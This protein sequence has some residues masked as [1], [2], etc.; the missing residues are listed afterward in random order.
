[1]KVLH[2][3]SVATIGGIEMLCTDIAK[4]NPK[5][6]VFAILF[7]G[8]PVEKQLED[9]GAHCYSLYHI[10]K[11]NVVDYMGKL[12]DICKSEQIDIVV[13]HH[14]GLSVL[15]YYML[16][17]RHLPNLKYVRYLHS[18]FEEK[19]YYTYGPLMNFFARR[20]MTAMYR[21]SDRLIAVSECVKNSFLQNFPI[22]QNKIRVIYNGISADTLH[23][24]KESY[25]LGKKTKKSE[26]CVNVIYMGRLEKV[27]GID[28]LI[29]AFSQLINEQT[30]MKL[31]LL[32]DGNARDEFEEL[33]HQKGIE[34]SVSFEGFQLEKEKYL[35][36]SDVFVYPSRCQEAFGISIIEAMSCGL[37]CIASKVGGIPEILCDG[38]NGYLFP[39]EDVTILKQ[40]LIIAMN[41]V[42]EEEQETIVANAMKTAN[43]FTI[44]KTIKK[45]NEVYHTIKLEKMEK[46]R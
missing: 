39:N 17:R 41:L 38:E 37:I 19:Y 11:W 27:K 16:L 8:G 10:P 21:K 36:K 40:K 18:V 45:L 42:K 31:Y 30:H 1:M 3:L 6:N 44:E 22:D 20:M 43:E 46:I 7:K 35:Q 13:I 28:I 5:N 4:E 25:L 12:C 15:V 33:V 2:L 14:E 24:N 29:E 23:K 34:K 32:G 9:T 26:E